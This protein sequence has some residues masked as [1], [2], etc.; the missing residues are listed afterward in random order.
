MRKLLT[1]ILFTYSSLAALADGGFNW[2]WTPKYF[3][4]IHIGYNTTTKVGGLNTYSAS[5]NIGTL[6]GV[7]INKYMQAG[8]GVDGVMFTHYYNGSGLRW[9]LAAY[10]DFRFLYPVN[11][12]FSPFINLALG[13]HIML[14]PGDGTSFYCEFGPGIKY[15]K[16]N[17]NCGLLHIGKGSGSN[18]FFVKTGFYF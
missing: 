13:A 7:S 18:H 14:K 9:A 5:A 4:E 2:E 15:K 10:S 16:F 11:D 8:A 17:L 3:G 12:K 1:I 6:Q